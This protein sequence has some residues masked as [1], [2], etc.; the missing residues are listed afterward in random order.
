MGNV[1]F[2]NEKMMNKDSKFIAQMKRVELYFQEFTASRWMASI[3]TGVPL[4]N[5]CRYVEMLSKENKIAV[6]RFDKCRISGEIVQFLS[7]NP[8]LFP[9]ELQLKFTYWNEVAQS[10]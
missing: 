2:K 10:H 4:Q 6:I 7:C 8:E 3:E 5:V 9:K 1:E